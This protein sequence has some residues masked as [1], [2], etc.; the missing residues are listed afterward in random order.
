[1]S[2]NNYDPSNV[3]AKII[4][5]EIPCK[6]IYEDDYVL[7]FYDI[8]PVAPV[9]VLVIPKGEYVNFSD[10]AINAPQEFFSH[11]YKKIDE[12]ANSLGLEYYR[13]ISNLGSES[14]QTV[15]H[16]HTHIISGKNLLGLIG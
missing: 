3:F 7:A 10:F 11:Y 9:H 2:K 8:A 12:I 15:F 14:G 5:G 6:K 1:M 16:F 4:R 13:L